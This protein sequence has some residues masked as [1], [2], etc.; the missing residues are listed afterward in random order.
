MH[1]TVVSSRPDREIRKQIHT[2]GDYSLVPYEDSRC[3]LE[4]TNFNFG[5]ES[6][7]YKKID[8]HSRIFA[9]GFDGIILIGDADSYLDKDIELIVQQMCCGETSKIFLIYKDSE[10]NVAI[11]LNFNIK[12][13][14]ITEEQLVSDWGWERLL[15]ASIHHKERGVELVKGKR[16]ADAFRRFSKSLKFLIAIEPVDPKVVDDEKMKEM[17]DLKVRILLLSLYLLYTV[18]TYY[19]KTRKV[20][21]HY[22]Y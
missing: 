14:E 2:Q 19:L 8:P 3:K 16:T 6:F 5:D 13:V 9:D 11:E 12:L 7:T 22:R 18:P 1:E 10:G 15:E 20:S 21:C 4:L 17:V